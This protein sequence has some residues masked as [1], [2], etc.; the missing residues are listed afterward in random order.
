MTFF[1]SK[2]ISML[3]AFVCWSP[4][5]NYSYSSME[6][7]TLC[8]LRLVKLI[9]IVFKIDKKTLLWRSAFEA[10]VRLKIYSDFQSFP[11]L[12]AYDVHREGALLDVDCPG[13]ES[14]VLKVSDVIPFIKLIV[15]A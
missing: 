4:G 9:A 14:V 12:L 6:R 1:V 11:E 8:E 7:K 15:H 10:N 13:A 5:K 3:T 2:K